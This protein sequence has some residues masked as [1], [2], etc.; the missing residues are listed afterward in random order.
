MAAVRLL[1]GYGIVLR[2]RLEMSMDTT[3]TKEYNVGFC[4]E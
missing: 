1:L 3:E 4:E 2:M